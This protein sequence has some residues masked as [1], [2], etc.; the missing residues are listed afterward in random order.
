MRDF[1]FEKIRHQSYTR[2]NEA[3]SKIRIEETDPDRK[4]IFYTALYHTMLDPRI[5]TDV[6]GRYVGGDKE[7]YQAG[8]FTKRTIFSGWDVFR[9]QFPLQTILN[10]EIVND[11]LNSL[12]T[13]GSQSGREYFERW[14]FLNAY[15]GCMLGNPA[16]SVLADA[17][18]KGIRG[19]DIE[20][21]YQYARNTTELFGNGEQGYVADGL[22]ISK[23]LE[24]GYTEWC[25][26]ELARQLGKK[27]DQ[28]KYVRRSASYKNIFDKEKTVSGPARLTV[29]SS[30]GRNPAG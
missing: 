29:H 10:P 23:T 8:S 18:A 12:I 19:Y 27:E 25:L 22:G 4:T 13:M 11:M 1:D 3:L 9:S 15:T 16:I 21:A 20:L 14:E 2:W 7:I 5:Y 24:Y 26:S 30:P 17:Y 28:E 6:D